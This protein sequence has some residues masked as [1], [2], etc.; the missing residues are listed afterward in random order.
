M[1]AW[2][3]G[4]FENDTACDFA[5]DVAESTGP[6]LLEKALDRVI[7]VGGDY[8]EAPDAVEAL[9]AADIVARLRGNPGV[10]T[11]YTARVDVWIA[12]QLSVPS[13]EIVG[14]ARRCVTRILTEPSEILEL[15]LESKN[16]EAWKR[17]V[18]EVA[19]RLK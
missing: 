13:E 14:K 8:L 19:E 9:A 16:F 5:A 1:G 3:S 10:Q 18:E 17:T 6:A 15:W 11:S 2:G 12:R 4:I 7:A